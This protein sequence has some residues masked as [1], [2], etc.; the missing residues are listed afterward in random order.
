M[1]EKGQA[2][3]VQ[4]LR[5]MIT[6]IETDDDFLGDF[7][8]DGMLKIELS[9][10]STNLNDIT[11]TSKYGFTMEHDG[12]GV[13]VMNECY[14]KDS[15]IDDDNPHDGGF[16]KIRTIELEKSKEIGDKHE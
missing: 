7:F 15:V 2:T 9:R 3:L 16:S 10:I 4:L 14:R 13:L 1:N 12:H 6:V 8:D 11:T 5:K